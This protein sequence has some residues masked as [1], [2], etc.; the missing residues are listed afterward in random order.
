MQNTRLD[1]QCFPADTH[2]PGKHFPFT[3]HFPGLLLP[4]P[5]SCLHEC[6][7]ELFFHVTVARFINSLPLP[8]CWW[9]ISPKN[10]LQKLRGEDRARKSG[11]SWFIVK[12]ARP[13]LTFHQLRLW[14]HRRRSF[15]SIFSGQMVGPVRDWKALDR[16]DGTSW[17]DYV[18]F[19]ISFRL[20]FIFVPSSSK[21]FAVKQAASHADWRHRRCFRA[22]RTKLNSRFDWIPSHSVGSTI[23]SVTMK[24]KMLQTKVSTLISSSTS[25]SVLGLDLQPSNGSIQMYDWICKHV[26]ALFG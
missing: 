9:I 26:W 20:I 21:P 24:R 22:R 15:L 1:S 7:P 14:L 13:I 19:A 3:Q 2:R 10:T 17:L 4:P 5:L 8:R 16:L 25:S 23:V 11:R 18:Q 6:L 12:S